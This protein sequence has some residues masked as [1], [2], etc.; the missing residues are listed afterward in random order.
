[1]SG[2]SLGLNLESFLHLTS[3]INHTGLITSF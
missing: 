3:L 2:N 1:M